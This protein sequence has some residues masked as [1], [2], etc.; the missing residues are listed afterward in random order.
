MVDYKK[1]DFI[2]DSDDDEENITQIISKKIEKKDND[3]DV[4][5]I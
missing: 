2:I 3:I 1:F 4:S 5:L